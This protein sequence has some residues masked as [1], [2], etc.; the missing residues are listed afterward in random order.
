MDAIS[1]P[2]KGFQSVLNEEWAWK[3]R[4]W[5]G[6]QIM[7]DTYIEKRYISTRKMY[8][9]TRYVDNMRGLWAHEVKVMGGAFSV[10]YFYDGVSNRTYFI[11]LSLWAPGE[12]KNVY[13]RQMELAVSTFSSRSSKKQTE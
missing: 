11:D 9:D 7:E 4:S 2:K 12:S 10:F 5:I 1:F 6:N 3:T 8:W 13:L